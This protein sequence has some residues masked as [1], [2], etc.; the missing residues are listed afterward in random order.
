M[1]PSRPP[2]V[3]EESFIP[4]GALASVAHVLAFGDTTVDLAGAFEVLRRMGFAQI[5]CEGGPHLLGALTAVVIHTAQKA[6]R[7]KSV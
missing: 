5:L 7:R 4:S 6:L 1:M 2:I 3:S